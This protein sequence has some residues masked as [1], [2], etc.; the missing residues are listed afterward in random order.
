MY[1]KKNVVVTI[2]VNIYPMTDSITL[3]PVTNLTHTA[4]GLTLQWN[5]AQFNNVPS[6][7]P[8]TPT[9]SGNYLWN[10]M[11]GGMYSVLLPASG[12][13]VNNDKEGYGWFSGSISGVLSFRGPMF[14][15]TTTGHP[16][17]DIV[18][19]NGVSASGTGTVQSNVVS[20]DPNVITSAAF[21]NTTAFPLAYVDSGLTKLARTGPIAVSGIVQA[22]VVQVSGEYVNIGSFGGGTGA[23]ASELW[24]YANRSLTTAVSVSGI[25][26]SDVVQVSGVSILYSP[27]RGLAGTALPNALPGASGGILIAGL[28]APVTIAGSGN[29]LTITSIGSNGNGVLVAGYGTGNGIRTFGGSGILTAGLY[30]K[31]SDNNGIGIYAEGDTSGIVAYPDILGDLTGSVTRVV[32]SV[33]VSGVAQVNVIQVSGVNTHT[34]PTIKQIAGGVLDESVLSHTALATLG[35][36]VID[37]LY[38]TAETQETLAASGRLDSWLNAIS[39]DIQ[40]IA[41][42]TWSYATRS[43]TNAVSVSGIP[44]VNVI[45]VSGEYVNIGSFGGGAGASAAEVWTYGSRELTA[46]VSV[47]GVPQVNLVQVSGATI[48]P[49]VLPKVNM[50]QVSGQFVN[51]NSF[52]TTAANIRTAVGL[53]TASLNTQLVN[54]S[55]YVDCLPVSWITPLDSGGLRGAIGL[56]SANLDSQLTGLSG[57]LVTANTAVYFANVKYVRD[58]INSQD[59]YSVVWFKNDQPVQSG[60]LTSPAISVFNTSTG[61][62]VVNNKKMSYASPNLGVVRYNATSSLLGSGEPYLV[63]VSGSIDSTVRTWRTIIGIDAF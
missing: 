58:N 42:D 9:D 43:L 30:A 35:K 25:V 10:N 1:L 55:G 28:N 12:G 27:I 4:S 34:I 6:G 16:M 56:S 8:I 62:A 45:Q 36:T 3:K 61:A 46:A 39:G 22:N 7:L 50:V 20:I 19:V 54:I 59:E 24:G 48:T 2:P 44:Q 14:N 21:D 26:Q 11:G 33:S 51:T 5:F 15:F 47:S 38:D 49:T 17:V 18:E 40:T 60:S 41:T 29:A 63:S 13:T 52:Q 32:N 31:G 37:I 23:S 53:N 57:D